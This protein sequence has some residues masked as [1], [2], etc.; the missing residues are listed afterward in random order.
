[1]AKRMF[2]PGEA[3]QQKNARLLKEGKQLYLIELEK[4]LDQLD[5]C[6]QLNEWEQEEGQAIY[7][8]LHTIKGSAPVFGIERIGKLAGELLPIWE[9]VA[10]QEKEHEDAC[11]YIPASVLE[12][13]RSVVLQMRMEKDVFRQ[14]FE[15]DEKNEQNIVAVSFEESS[16]L[17][18]DDDEVLSQYLKRRLELDG[19]RVDEAADVETAKRLLRTNKYDLITLDLMMHPHSGYELFEFLKEDPSLKWVPLIVLSGRNDLKDKVRCFYLGSDDYVTK[20]FE[21]EELAARIFGLLKRTKSFEDMA[22]RDPLTGVYNRRYFDHHV[23]MELLRHKR[24]PAPLSVVFIDIDKFKLVNDT[25]GHGVGDMV[26]QGLTHILQQQLRSSDLLA[27]YGGEE[28]VVL[29]PNTTVQDAMKAM[30]GILK[31][32]HSLP[33]AHHDGKPLYITFSAGVVEWV[34]GNTKM[35][36]LRQA[37]E[38]MYQAKL[39][40]RNRVLRYDERLDEQADC[41]QAQQEKR[42]KL[43]IAEDDSILRSMLTTRFKALPI[44]ILA[45]ENGDEALRLLQEY[46]PE[47]A[48]LDGVLPGLHGFDILIKLRADE[49]LKETKVLMLSGSGKEKDIVRGLQLGADDYMAKPFSLVELELRVKRL[50][51]IK[52]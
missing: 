18:I 5:V 40:G 22:F 21:Y 10:E 7:R 29:M 26:L 33:M 27:R 45:A 32:V 30:E 41:I 37:D 35:N 50:L 44:D 14:E 25:Y 12:K 39:Q 17:L 49:K 19:Y 23:D 31:R 51:D 2:E 36:W 47:V 28:F 11:M 43:L 24:H 6:L 3:K 34:E 42:K 9:A 52:S 15:L 20:P 8:I 1:M 48:I 16:I 46:Q 4:Q 38:A 13:T